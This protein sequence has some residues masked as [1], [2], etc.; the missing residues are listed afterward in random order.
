MQVCQPISF[1]TSIHLLYNFTF[2][3]SHLHLFFKHGALRE[4]IIFWADPVNSV[5]AP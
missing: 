5:C 1:P 3:T 4:Q 2:K